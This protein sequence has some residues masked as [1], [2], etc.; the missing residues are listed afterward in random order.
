MVE[1]RAA[2]RDASPATGTREGPH[3]RERARASQKP[4]KEER[5]TH[6]G[7]EAD[8][9]NPAD[10]SLATTPGFEA[11]G[12]RHARLT[13][14]RGRGGVDLNGARRAQGPRRRPG[15]HTITKASRPKDCAAIQTKKNEK[16]NVKGLKGEVVLQGSC[17]HWGSFPSNL[18]AFTF[19]FLILPNV[20]QAPKF[21]V[22]P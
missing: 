8:D 18:H 20:F 4:T 21:A 9:C 5:S 2:G 22:E 6:V 10:F 12:D 17:T 19:T 14:A 11:I 15:H 7:A 3:R 13:T 16:D 1:G